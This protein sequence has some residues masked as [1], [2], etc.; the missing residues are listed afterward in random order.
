MEEI[1]TIIYNLCN[2]IDIVN[3]NKRIE[4]F[5]KENKD[6]ISKNKFRISKDDMELER[7]LET[8]KHIE[9]I[10][11]RELQELEMVCKIKFRLFLNMY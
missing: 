6:V 7:I 1:E 11:Q 2:N 9:T 8:E 3:T 4:Q 5:K 10:R